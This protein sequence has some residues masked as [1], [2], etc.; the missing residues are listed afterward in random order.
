MKEELE[1]KLEYLKKYVDELKLHRD[2]TAAELKEDR[3]T[4]A[5]IE[6]FFQMAIEN[7]IDICS[8]IIS[9]KGLE[10]PD[11]YRKIILKLGEEGILERSFSERF[12][13]VAGFRNVLVHQYAEINIGKLHE[14]LKM[15]LE[16]FDSFA[17]QIAKYL[18]NL[19]R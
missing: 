19:K 3:L 10:K 9:H 17:R 1:K 12:A 4:R 11:E 18:K 2:I 8:M 5:A 6:R 7:V 16:D 14:N 13:D 15:R